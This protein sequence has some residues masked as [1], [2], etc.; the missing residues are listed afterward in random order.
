VATQTPTQRSAAAKR[1]A[2]TRKRNA[3]K[4]SALTYTDSSRLARQLDRFE[5]RGARAI[6]RGRRQ[7]RRRAR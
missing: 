3:T 6:D 4:R 7:V 5:R 2:A 1:A